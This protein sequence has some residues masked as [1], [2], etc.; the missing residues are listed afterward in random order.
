MFL[1]LPDL[2]PTPFPRLET[3]EYEGSIN[4]R[5]LDYLT[6]HSPRLVSLE[7]RCGQSVLQPTCLRWEPKIN[8]ITS[9]K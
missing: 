2:C 8:S 5:V 4:S 3:L 1:E 7:L 9:K 6:S